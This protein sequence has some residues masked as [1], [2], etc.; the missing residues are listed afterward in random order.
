[1]SSATEPS[2]QT[3]SAEEAVERSIERHVRLRT[4]GQVRNL[5][6]MVRFSVVCLEGQCRRYYTKQL[7]S[8]AA[9]EAFAELG[10]FTGFE[11]HN[12]IDVQRP[13]GL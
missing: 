10:A 12:T 6:V 3:K 7:A 5:T 11:V 1:M 13:I 4:H 9:L 2:R 8:Q